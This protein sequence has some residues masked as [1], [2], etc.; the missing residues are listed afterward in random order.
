MSISN[1]KYDVFGNKHLLINI[2]NNMKSFTHFVFTS[3]AVVVEYGN[4][5]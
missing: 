4:E 2:V 5:S 3:V 1:A